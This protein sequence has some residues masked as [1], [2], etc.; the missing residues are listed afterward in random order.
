MSLKD[1]GGRIAYANCGIKRNKQKVSGA[2]YQLQP[3]VSQDDYNLFQRSNMLTEDD[4]VVISFSHHGY[5]A[6]YR[7]VV[8]L[9][10]ESY[11]LV[12][13]IVS[14]SIESVV[15]RAIVDESIDDGTID[16]GRLTTR[17]TRKQTSG[18]TGGVLKFASCITDSEVFSGVVKHFKK[19]ISRDRKA[20]SRNVILSITGKLVEKTKN[21]FVIDWYGGG[22][23]TITRSRTEG[24]WDQLTI[25]QWIE[26]TI[27]RRMTGEVVAAMLVG[28]IEEPQGFSGE[29]LTESY[30]SIPAARLD[31]VE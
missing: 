3:A 25:G 13:R 19:I 29:E 5:S 15:L 17:V 30:S 10:G 27:S 1:Y 8:V 7:G 28:T 9:N 4:A 22:K 31:P 2:R 12:G 18:T 21:Y 11:E 14:G 6:A 20:T 26:A 24:D 16:Y 23:L